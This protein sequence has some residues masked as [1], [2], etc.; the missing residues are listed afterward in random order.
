[1][2]RHHLKDWRLF[3]NAEHFQSEG[4]MNYILLTRSG[5][6]III[7]EQIQVSTQFYLLDQEGF[8]FH[9]R[10]NFNVTR[11]TQEEQWVEIIEVIDIEC[12]LLSR[13]G[14]NFVSKRGPIPK[15]SFT[16]SRPLFYW[17]QWSRLLWWKISRGF[18]Y[19]ARSEPFKHF[20]T[21]LFLHF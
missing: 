2:K 18:G 1:M 16:R 17:G 21:M 3:A 20:F 10:L 14:Q 13:F 12:G 4:I 9:F 8:R 19:F 5:R 11:R 6:H 7:L 15:G